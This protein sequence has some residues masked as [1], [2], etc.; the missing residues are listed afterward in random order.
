MSDPEK[1]SRTPVPPYYAVVFSSQRTEGDAGYDRMAAAMSDLAAMQ[2][3]YLGH[4]SARSAD[5]FGITVSYWRDEN[6]VRRWKSVVEHQAAQVLG[7]ELW[8]SHYEVRIAKVE[9][10]YAGPEGRAEALAAASSLD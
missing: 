5:G 1:F 8:Y 3:G 9:R 6:S 4:E 10:A 7:R 2:P